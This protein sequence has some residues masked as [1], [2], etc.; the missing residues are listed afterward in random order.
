METNNLDALGEKLVSCNLDCKGIRN[1]PQEG[2]IPRCLILEQ[3]RGK[4]KSI[5]V[6]LNP[7]KC[8]LLEKQFY[9][10]NGICYQSIKDH[11]E[12]KLKE[13]PYFRKTRDLISLL[14][15]D[16]DILW[17]ELAKCECSDKNGTLPIQTLRNCINE[18][19]RKEI[20]LFD[21]KVIFALGNK[22]FDFCALSF[23]KHFVIGIP[24]PSGSYGHFNKLIEKIKE[25]KNSYIKELKNGYKKPIA[26]RISEI[27]DKKDYMGRRA[28]RAKKADFRKIL[29]KVPDRKPLFGDEL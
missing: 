6:G 3:R 29:N 10:T 20:E 23:P 7:G 16:G 22:A 15:Y 8:K 14:E 2:I 19:L 1:S 11:F 12:S 17:T 18:F 9:L 25:N 24:H 26:I 21:C 27:S 4:K 28:K 13:S 5:V